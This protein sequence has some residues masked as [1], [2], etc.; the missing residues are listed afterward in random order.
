MRRWHLQIAVQHILEGSKHWGVYNVRDLRILCAKYKRIVCAKFKGIV[1]AK[2]KR[3]VSQSIKGL[4]A[5][6]LKRLYAQGINGLYAQCIK[7]CVLK[8]QMI[9]LIYFFIFIQ[10]QRMR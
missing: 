2:Y 6:S 7:C 1:C 10:L 4:Y 3:I 8:V 9:L 5:Q